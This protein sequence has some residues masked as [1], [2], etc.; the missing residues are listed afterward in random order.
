MFPQGGV[1][2]YGSE[3]V[4]GSFIFLSR[5][6]ARNLIAGVDSL[7]FQTA[8][9][10][11][12]IKSDISSQIGV[13]ISDADEMQC[14]HYPRRNWLMCKVGDVIYNYNYTPF[15]S[16]G[17]VNPT[18]YGSWSTF[19]TKLAQMKCYFV[20]KNGDLICAG[21]GGKVY[22]YDT[23]SYSDD[24]DNINTIIET[25]WLTLQEPQQSTQMKCGHYIRT[26]F[27]AG[28]PVTYTITAT[29]DFSQISTDTVTVTAEGVGQVGFAQVGTSPVGGARILDKKLPLR[30]K[31]KQFKIRVE[32]NDTNGPDIVTGFTIYGNILG[33]V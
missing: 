30:W 9:V 7:T 22:K 4:G 8:N 14:I 10:S 31:G 19:N 23:G 5:D 3:S 26:Q 6:G 13:K 25:G 27:E 28:T 33:K 16:R 17:E 11:E 1:S 15:Y 32:T 24:G 29:G 20:R 21:A 12:A 2:R 18:P